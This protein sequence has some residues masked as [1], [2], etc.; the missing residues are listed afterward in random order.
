MD[1]G[2]GVSTLPLWK[3]Q[4]MK[5]VGSNNMLYLT[6]GIDLCTQAVCEP[7]WRPMKRAPFESLMIAI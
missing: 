4:V 7:Y 3:K 1:L 5:R 2:S 6:N